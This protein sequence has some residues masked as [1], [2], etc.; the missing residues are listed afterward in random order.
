E[1]CLG[2][3]DHITEILFDDISAWQ[4]GTGSEGGASGEAVDPGDLGSVA[5]MSAVAGTG[6]DPAV[7]SFAGQLAGIGAGNSYGLTLADGSTLT[8]TVVDVQWDGDNEVSRWLVEPASTAFPAQTVS[9][10]NPAADAPGETPVLDGVGRIR[11]D[12]PDLF[13]GDAAGQ[14]GGVVG[15]VDVLM[16]AADQAQNDYL[17]SLFGAE[18]PHYR[19]LCSLVFREPYLGLSPYFRPVSVRLHSSQIGNGGG[20]QWYAEKATIGLEGQ[21]ASASTVTIDPRVHGG[22]TVA[23]GIAA[24]VTVSGFDPSEIV[25]FSLQ[26]GQPFGGIA[27]TGSPSPLNPGGRTGTGNGFWVAVDGDEASV[28]I[29]GN[30]GYVYDGY[31]AAAAAFPGGSVTGGEAYTFFIV[32]TP[33]ADN[34][35]EMILELSS[36]SGADKNPAHIIRQ[37]LTDPSYWQDPIPE[38]LIGSSFT[39]A[40]DLFF[41]EGFGL[42][43][44]FDGSPEDAVSEVLRHVDAIL[45][46]DRRTGLIEIRAI[47]D[48]YDPAGLLVID[49]DAGDVLEWGDFGR[50]EPSELASQ[51]TVTFTDR[52]T[53][54]RN[55]VTDHNQALTTG[56]RGRAQSEEYLG[57]TREN[58]AARV[59]A[60]ELR[61]RSQQVWRGSGL[62]LSRKAHDLDPGDRFILRSSRRDLDVVLLVQEVDLGSITDVAISV[63]VVEDV[64]ALG[65][66]AIGG[67]QTLPGPA[68]NAPS[69]VLVRDVREAPYWAM[70]QQFGHAEADAQLASDPDGGL[71]LAAGSRPSADAYAAE[72]W[73][74]EGAGAVQDGQASFVPTAQLAGALSDLPT[75]RTVAVTGW[76][77]RA[78]VLP[79]MIASI[80]AELVRIDVVSADSVTLG[81]G[82]LDTVP[83]AHS[84]GAALIVWGAGVA[85]GSTGFT[86]GQDIDV[87]LLTFTP[88]GRLALASAAVDQLAFDARQIRPLPPGNVQANGGY[89]V[90]AA[91]LG[92]GDVVLTWAHRD[93]LTQTSP[94]LY[95]YTAGDIGPE[96]GV[97]YEVVVRWIDPGT[98]LP[99]DPP[100]AQIDAGTA[101]TYTLTAAD[102]PDALAPVGVQLCEVRVRAKRSVGGADYYEWQNRSFRLLV[103]P[104]STGYGFN[105][106]F[107]YGSP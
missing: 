9:V 25:V 31:A 76:T 20:A 44:Q 66:A 95:D 65:A 83:A 78:D 52:A 35:G 23:A 53:D 6:G 12:A 69:A 49:D 102:I 8:V 88:R 33:L 46:V 81:R 92:S 36:V 84:A 104:G 11:I 28:Q 37:E 60:R 89:S 39:A 77:D 94:I 5:G 43:F 97:T 32:D 68:T 80:G 13:G 50:S 1:L 71:V 42:S 51:M 2:P 70:V 34:T 3:V 98:D 17:A 4:R 64:F 7:I 22:S 87:R 63:D 48:D 41:A 100:A 16:G 99:I 93:R 29:F 21:G 26:P 30:P 59:C 56:L 18:T 62:V 14:E 91:A 75:A 57:I 58:L 72:I 90:P 24:G 15:D 40:A 38:A 47:R 85:L 55:S 79:G 73:V 86:A 10:D 74:D 82:V 101:N 45:Y 61:A 67:A 103:Q 105:Y 27:V 106:G 96:V 107:D 54:E 19:G